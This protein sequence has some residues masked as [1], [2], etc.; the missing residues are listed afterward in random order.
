MLYKTNGKTNK[1]IRVPWEISQVGFVSLFLYKLNNGTSAPDKTYNIILQ[2][3][4]TGRIGLPTISR[5]KGTDAPRDECV[6]Y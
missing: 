5:I 3:R 2:T 1:S 6:F 4:W